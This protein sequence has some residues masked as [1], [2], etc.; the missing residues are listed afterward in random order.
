[1]IV[2][3]PNYILHAQNGTVET[4]TNV[5]EG[6]SNSVGAIIGSIFSAIVLLLSVFVTATLSVICCISWVK[7]K[8]GHTKQEVEVE[9]YVVKNVNYDEKINSV[10][11]AK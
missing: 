4:T 1:M 8:G 2:I 3:V 9:M 7:S 10:D 5:Q 11:E 6:S